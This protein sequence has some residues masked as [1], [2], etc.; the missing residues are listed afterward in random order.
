MDLFEIFVDELK[1]LVEERLGDGYE[2]TVEERI[3]AVNETLTGLNIKRKDS[4]HSS[5]I[6]L[7]EIYQKVEDGEWDIV[8]AVNE[9]KEYILLLSS[10]VNIDRIDIFENVKERIFGC[11]INMRLNGELLMD[12]PYIE[13]E[14]LALVFRVQVGDMA[15]I[16]VKNNLLSSWGVDIETLRRYAEKNMVRDGFEL[17]DLASFFM[18]FPIGTGIDSNEEAPAMFALTNS[19]KINGAAVILLDEVKAMLKERFC[20]APLWVL[21]SSINE[22]LLMEKKRMP[23][24]EDEIKEMIRFVNATALSTSEFLSDN[25]YQFEDGEFSLYKVQ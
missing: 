20:D 22:F 9:I 4:N 23:K 24:S 19:R 13:V 1:S 16:L 5:V 2:V 3:T 17:I 15:S 11:L 21:P 7:E 8:D 25:L 18:P 6:Y 14:D 12:V 10:V